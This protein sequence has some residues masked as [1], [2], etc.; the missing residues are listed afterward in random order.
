MLSVTVSVIAVI[1]SGPAP[2]FAG[3]CKF[4][5]YHVPHFVFGVSYI[6]MGRALKN[7]N[8]GWSARPF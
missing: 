3:L 8:S 4:T 1:S 7:A 6:K 5:L 2:D